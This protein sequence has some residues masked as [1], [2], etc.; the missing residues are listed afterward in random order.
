M[1]KRSK[2]VNE[3]KKSSLNSEWINW[4]KKIKNKK[5]KA[6]KM[7]C[8]STGPLGSKQ[9]NVYIVL[10]CNMW[11]EREVMVKGERDKTKAR[12]PPCPHAPLSRRVYFVTPSHLP[13]SLFICLWTAIDSSAGF[14]YSNVIW[15]SD[16]LWKILRVILKWLDVPCWFSCHWWK[17]SLGRLTRGQH[18]GRQQGTDFPCNFLLLT[19]TTW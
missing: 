7:H 9:A 10:T 13:Q 2:I 12:L 15:A 3:F 6:S 4:G 19:L 8:P 11:W 18:V 17:T 5:E 16:D 14:D 1:S